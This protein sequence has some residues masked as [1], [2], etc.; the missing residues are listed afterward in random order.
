MAKRSSAFLFLI[1][2]FFI[3]DTSTNAGKGG[4]GKSK[5]KTSK[6]APCG[7]I[8]IRLTKDQLEYSDPKDKPDFT[9]I[10]FNICAGSC[11][12]RSQ[13]FTF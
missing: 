3:I 1:I 9:R 8:K 7:L 6:E 10:D 2:A 4:D 12:G 5:M 13:I 11:Q